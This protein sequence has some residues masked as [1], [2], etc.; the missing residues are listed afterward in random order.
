MYNL[1]FIRHGETEGN[2]QNILQGQKDTLLTQKGVKDTQLFSSHFLAKKIDKVYCSDL[3]R[4]HDTANILFKSIPIEKTDLVRERN[5]GSFNGKPAEEYFS[6]MKHKIEYRNNLP[7]EERFSY[8]V[9][10]DIESDKELVI[11]FTSFIKDVI[12]QQNKLNV[13]VVTHGG[14]MRTLLVYLKYGIYKEL[15]PESVK[16]LGYMHIQTDG[17]S[18]I[19]RDTYNIFKL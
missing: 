1:Y 11:R 13:A 7:Y 8:K 4:C 18:F 6:T 19:V 12:L 17:S 10:E 5:F 3:K 15:P 2:I 9:A 14:F 16:N